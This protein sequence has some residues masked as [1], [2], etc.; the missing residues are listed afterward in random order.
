MLSLSYVVYNNHTNFKN[1]KVTLPVKVTFEQLN[2]NSDFNGIWH[3]YTLMLEK[4]H[5]IAAIPILY[6]TI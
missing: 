2:R 5:S 3:G 1:S 6:Y 4:G